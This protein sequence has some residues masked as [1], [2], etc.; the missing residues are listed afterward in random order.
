M[1]EKL[2]Q[3]LVTQRGLLA[4]GESSIIAHR[5]F[6]RQKI[7][8]ATKKLFECTFVTALSAIDNDINLE[9]ILDFICA[10]AQ[11]R[12]VYKTRLDESRNGRRALKT[13]FTSNS[14]VC[15]AHRR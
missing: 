3:G 7:F 9:K 6:R 13:K 12:D 8:L 1:L 4:R 11:E 10:C 15:H 5:F 14:W 2:D